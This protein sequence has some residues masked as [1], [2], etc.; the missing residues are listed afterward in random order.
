M[1]YNKQQQMENDK[2][3]MQYPSVMLFKDFR[4]IFPW[5]KQEKSF[6]IPEIALS[7]IRNR[8]R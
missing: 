6:S 2:Q 3:N 8:Y 5:H 1:K 4:K 7:P